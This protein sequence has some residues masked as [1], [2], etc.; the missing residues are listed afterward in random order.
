MVVLSNNL[1]DLVKSGHPDKISDVK[2]LKTIFEG[3]VSYEAA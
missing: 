3:E 1:F 2:V